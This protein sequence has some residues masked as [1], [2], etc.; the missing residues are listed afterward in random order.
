MSTPRSPE[1]TGLPV[2]LTS[3]VGRA[4]EIEEIAGLLS[5]SRLVT[6]TG[7]GGCGKTRLALRAAEC[8]AGRESNAAMFVDLAALAAGGDPSIAIARSAGLADDDPRPR[9]DRIV[10]H[11]HRRGPTLTVLDNCEHLL[12]SVAEV[13]ER[14][15]HAC[16]QLRV[17]CTSRTS[18]DLAG[19]I[20][21]RVPSL[22]LPP[23]DASDETRLAAG[24][25]GALFLDRARAVE[26]RL[27]VTAADAAAVAEICRR[28]DGIPLAL[29]LAAA[30]TRVLTP[31]HIALALRDRVDVPGSGR[32]RMARHRTLAAS[33][34][35]SH[36][37]LSEPER[38]MLRRLGVLHGTFDLAAVAA[39]AAEF[40]ETVD[41]L[42][43]LTRLVDSSLVVA[44]PLGAQARFGLLETVRQYAVDKLAASEDGPA[45]RHAHRRHYLER[46]QRACAA[47]AG[48]GQD[49][50]LAEMAADFENYRAAFVE[51]RRA[52]DAGG[53]LQ[54]AAALWPLWRMRGR[55]AEGRAWLDEALAAGCGRDADRLVALIVRNRVEVG[56]CG[57]VAADRVDETIRLAREVG[58]PV[59]LARALT[60]GI[61][62]GFRGPLAHRP[63]LEEA[64]ALA[65]TAGDRQL[66]LEVQ[67]FAI[68]GAVTGGDPQRTIDL[69]AEARRRAPR[70]N[71]YLDRA[72]TGM[73]GFGLA[74]RGQARLAKAEIAGLV[75]QTQAVG[76]CTGGT[77][78]AS[79]WAWVAA[80]A[81]NHEAAADAAL[82]GVEHAAQSGLRFE[83]VFAHL[84]WG[85]SLLARGDAPGAARA[86]EQ[87]RELGGGAP[88]WADLCGAPSAVALC[89]AG[90]LPA[91]RR[92]VAGSADRVLDPMLPWQA[93]WVW[94]AHA[95]IAAAEGRRD[96]AQTCA[97]R[98]L[99]IRLQIEDV[100][101]AADI[102]ELLAVHLMDR[103]AHA[104]GARLLGCAAAR[105]AEAGCTRFAVHDHDVVEAVRAAVAAL[106]YS[107]YANAEADG[108]GL[109]LAEAADFA[110]R[111]RG[112]RPR[113]EHGWAA[114]T[115]TERQVAEHV[116]AG[117]STNDIA[118]RLFV[119][120]RTVQ[121]H[122]TRTYDKLGVRSRVQ[123]ARAVHQAE[124]EQ[125]ARI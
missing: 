61:S 71:P 106:G 87:G 119:S 57:A 38:R 45:A 102:L 108:A 41:A 74:M 22:G 55:R 29:E 112:P 66:W 103:Q 28:L 21:W 88:G 95:R 32:G 77:F 2:A 111:L 6:I 39:I 33:M 114:L 81:G 115:K 63:L 11:L 65:E 125:A 100:V 90:D 82:R 78:A 52:D 49:D 80:L 44:R 1:R 99:A 122:L 118:E 13:A 47:A 35:W 107:A 25:A 64:A 101:G 123:L 48:P 3:F 73:G 31:T 5:R 98:S 117:L 96:A 9:L 10:E 58:D 17:L 93:G 105:R 79:G 92:R 76:D 12:D 69:V 40:A 36:E 60:G 68:F 27:V 51:C 124:A 20:S 37:L 91:A 109:A 67:L 120:P 113:A 62:Y 56:A 19:E 75:E 86:W 34:D 89:A 4:M 54:L 30:A 116:A 104:S 97:A 83:G 26:P 84:A 18:L 50:V 94:E 15:L 8:L 46:A 85:I 16:P 14:L 23:A 121:S 24:E 59:L 43:P 72:I 53:A 70:T 42:D 110:L 7:P